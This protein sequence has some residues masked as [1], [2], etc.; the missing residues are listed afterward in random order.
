MVTPINA[1]SIHELIT[2]HADSDGKLLKD[3][4]TFLAFAAM[5]TACEPFTPARGLTLIVATAGAALTAAANLTAR[6]A[7]AAQNETVMPATADRFGILY[8]VLAQRCYIESIQQTLRRKPPKFLAASPPENTTDRAVAIK[9]LL[10]HRIAELTQADITY[11]FGDAPDVEKLFEAFNHWLTAA[12]QHYGFSD[13]V[14]NEFV[15]DCAVQSSVLLKCRLA[16]T[17]ADSTWMRNFLAISANE[18]LQR[19]LED[20][21][22]SIKETL[23]QFEDSIVQGKRSRVDSWDAYRNELKALPDNKES[24][25]NENFGV[26][27]LFITPKTKYH[28]A[29][30]PGE[31]GR[32]QLRQKIGTLLGALLSNRVANS[33]L[34]ML[35]GG[36]GSGK[37][38]LCQLIASELATDPKIHPVFLRLRRVRD[39]T[40][41]CQFIETQFRQLGLINQYAELRDIPNLVLIL[42]GFDEIASASRVKIRYLLESLREQLIIGPIAKAKIIVSG[43]DTLFPRGEGLP[44]GSHVL[45][46]EPFDKLRIAKW[47]R[48]WRKIHKGT[49]GATFFPERLLEPLTDNGLSPRSLSPLLTWPLT[50]HLLAKC[51]TSGTFDINSDIDLQGGKAYLYRTILRDAN[52]RQ[53]EKCTHSPEVALR[54]L[55]TLA[56]RMY[57]SQVYVLDSDAVQHIIGDFAEHQNARV[58]DEVADWAIVSAPILKKGEEK[59]FEFVHKSFQEFFVAE[60]IA[61]VIEQLCF[62]ANDYRGEHRWQM[63][64]DDAVSNG[65]KLLSP[66]LL[67]VEVQEFLEVIL[68]RYLQFSNGQALTTSADAIAQRDQNL[69]RV[70]E[71]VSW[72]YSHALNGEPIRAIVSNALQLPGHAGLYESQANYIAGLLLIGAAAARQRHVHG[73]SAPREYFNAEPFTGAFWRCVSLLQAGGLLVD[74]HLSKRLPDTLSVYCENGTELQDTVTPSLLRMLSDVR[75]YGN[76]LGWALLGIVSRIVIERFLSDKEILYFIDSEA[77]LAPLETRDLCLQAMEIWF[78]SDSQIELVRALRIF[79]RSGAGRGKKECVEEMIKNAKRLRLTELDYECLVEMNQTLGTTPN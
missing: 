40:D 32:P 44:H 21:L 49:N 35:C 52:A 19:Q 37:S 60:H 56:W 42:D 4:S 46:L 25:F 75:G 18:R 1:K 14:A 71:R 66:V 12:L 64:G 34:I 41:I 47:S 27:A 73:G 54:W 65:L 68:G 17:D 53:K 61:D 79:L 50:L 8:F 15:K 70:L 16:E 26:R 43:R 58:M 55:R 23:S 6:F 22:I 39:L 5:A 69:S 45:T 28:I 13:Q 20:G 62:K 30:G 72:L 9:S 24:M 74:D 29:G 11:L 38:T 10:E 76:V 51:H 57:V 59:G 33:S 7:V 63:S 31:S 2:K 77:D 36:P 48:K 78:P 67:P 3:A